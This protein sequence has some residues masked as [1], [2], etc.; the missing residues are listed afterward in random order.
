MGRVKILSEEV[1]S[2]IAAGEVIDRPASVVK[3][4]LENSLDAEASEISI[5]VRKAGRELIQ[6]RDNGSGIEPEDIATIFLRHATSKIFRPADL[7][8]ITSLGFRGEALYSI[9]AVSDV[10]LRSRVSR[11][12]TGKEIHV[13]GGVKLG[14]KTISLPVGTEIEVRELFFNTPARRKFLRKD[15]IEFRQIL[16]TI[17]PYTLAYPR[18]QFSLSH[19]RR[20][21]LELPAREETLERI[22]ECLGTRKEYL[23]ATELNFPGENLK[24][25]LI[26]GDINVR[27][28]RRDF[29][30]IYVNNRPVQ[31]RVISAALNDVYRHLLPPETNGMFVVFVFVP[32]ERV[33]VN[34]HPAKREVKLADEPGIVLQLKVAAERFLLTQ[35]KMKQV[36]VSYPEKID[37]GRL[38]EKE[39]KPVS[40]EETISQRPLTPNHLF[41][42]EKTGDFYSGGLREKLAQARQ[43]G[44]F[45]NKYI[46]FESAG[47]LIIL[48][49]HAAHE[50]IMFEEF[51]R[52]L[53]TGQVQVQNLLTPLVLELSPE[54]MVIWKEGK[55]V[56]EE[57]GFST[58]SL[59]RRSI[60]IHAYPVVLLAPDVSLRSVLSGGNL[61]RCDR[62]TLAQR[63][64]RCSVMAGRP[65]VSEEALSL[66]D[67]L[68]RCQ[69]PFTCPHGRPTAVEIKESFLDHQF[70]RK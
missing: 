28:P 4:L 10:I 35:G 18:V 70:L 23:I 62:K 30:F 36:E 67:N 27:R 15:E 14:E 42:A 48:D 20:V 54:E 37:S 46:L 2:R 47:A 32:P 64:C 24:V 59:D 9:A 57:M 13:R 25:S 5:G 12:E 34:V 6:V 58:T 31:N 56:L 3:E 51:S 44:V 41:L 39:L 61:K 66:R 38:A 11:E 49:Q 29:Q 33:D 22:E 8:M 16:S 68:L 26:L 45:A 52:Q 17:L 53:E 69:D 1:I 60:A 40:S 50:R 63:A 55:A 65:L 21:V 19:N 7:Q 43:V